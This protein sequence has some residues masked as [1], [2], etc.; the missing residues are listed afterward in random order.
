MPT[1]S[2]PSNP[3]P[4]DTY[5]FNGKTWI[6]NGSAWDLQSSGAI[7][8]IPVGNAVPASGAFTTL[9]STGNTTL[10]EINSN[11]VPAANGIYNLGS[12]SQQWLGLYLT[13]NTI[14]LGDIQ[15]KN[16]G[17]NTL[18]VFAADGTTPGSIAGEISAANITGTISAA[19]YVTQNAQANITSVG[20]L[21]SLSVT[22]N[23][24]TDQYFI[25]NGSQLTGIAAGGGSTTV[26][27]T[28][29]ESPNQGDVWIDSDTGIQFIYFNDGNS[30]QWAEME[31]EQSFYY[32]N[33]VTNSPGGSAG[34]IQYNTGEAFGG[35]ENLTFNGT[36]LT[37]VDLSVTG[38]VAA[39]L[40]MGGFGILNLAAPVAATDAATKQY[41]DEVAEGLKT[42][43]A[44]YLAT[45][46]NLTANYNNGASGVGATLTSTTNG[47]FPLVDGMQANT[48]PGFN[49]ILVKNQSTPSQNGR[50]N[51][52]TLGD[53]SNPWV[54]TRCS[55]CDTSSE[56][57]GSYIFVTEGDTQAGTGWVLTVADPATFVIGTDA[58]TAFQ[59]AGAGTYTAGT[60]LT[61]TGTQFSVNS[62]QT[63]ITEVG[64]LGNLTVGGTVTAATV[65]PTYSLNTKAIVE[66]IT[67]TA[68]APA[69]TTAFDAITQ[70]IQYYTT[71]A[72]TNFTLNI[73]GNSSVTMNDFMSTGQSLTVVLLV[74]NGATPYYA[75]VI[76]V[77]GN[78]V[79]PKWQGG[80]AVTSG[81]ANS[82]DS[83]TFTLIKTGA[84]TFTVLGSQTKFA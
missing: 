44:A 24:S 76:Q 74:T 83:Y 68:A 67:V 41:V 59:F 79:S 19:E 53:G 70:S 40:S 22:G 46:T 64:T 45:T 69:A 7:N 42:K 17:S 1:L 72:N 26:S 15:L 50:Y 30:S 29:P 28:P 36:Q 39:N 14:Y 12:E 60:G 80:T 51:L 5:S 77:D 9:I 20:T 54:L 81:N 56:I 21:S 32:F 16:N 18:G 65:T 10:S 3:S 58:I 25:G 82:V 31:A 43:P 27:S 63:Q 61:L 78:T 38:N 6:Y 2:F 55:L 52:T 66:T 37:T 8:N 73:R 23:I 34:Q 13:G 84:N 71:N 11:L 75:N 47:Q 57:P 4:N 35:S 48:S 62:S 49:G 33:N